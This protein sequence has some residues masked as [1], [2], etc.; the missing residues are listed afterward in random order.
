MTAPHISHLTIPTY[1]IPFRH[2]TPPAADNMASHR[3]GIAP[4]GACR[5]GHVR[6]GAHM[7]INQDRTFLDTLSSGVGK[8]RGAAVGHRGKHTPQ[9]KPAHPL[10]AVFSH[11]CRACRYHRFRQRILHAVSL[12]QGADI[13][14]APRARFGAAQLCELA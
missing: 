11:G 5:I 6:P 10:A 12:Q 7:E 2:E 14:N 13:Y 9:V 8:G 4:A 1:Q 3:T